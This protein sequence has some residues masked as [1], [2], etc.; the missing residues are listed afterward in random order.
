[1]PNSSEPDQA[2]YF[3]KQMDSQ[4]DRHDG[5]TDKAMT[6]SSLGSLSE[7]VFWDYFR[8]QLRNCVC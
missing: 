2:R 7:L 5:K 8:R 3:V 1:M 6:I 4:K